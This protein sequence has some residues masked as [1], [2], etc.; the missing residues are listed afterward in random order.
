MPAAR[1]IGPL[2]T[3]GMANTANGSWY[4]VQIVPCVFPPSFS[5]FSVTFSSSDGMQ[6]VP[7]T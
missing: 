4:C 3:P 1:A 5:P 2:T 6:T 7:W